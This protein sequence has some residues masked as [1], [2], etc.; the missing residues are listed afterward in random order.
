MKDFK[1]ALQSDGYKAYEI[2][3]EK[4]GVQLLACMAHARR[5][6]DEAKD[7]DHKRATIALEYIQQLYKIECKARIA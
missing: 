3:A 5:K 1:D 7:N 2:F 4:Q 6:F